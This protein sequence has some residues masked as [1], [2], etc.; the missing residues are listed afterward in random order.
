MLSPIE[1]HGPESI[2]LAGRRGFRYWV[3]NPY[4]LLHQADVDKALSSFPLVVFLPN[5]DPAHTPVLIGLQGM[6]APMHWN[7]FLVPHLV[8]RGIACVL[9]ETPLAGERSLILDG[10]DDILRKMTPLVERGIPLTIQL[11]RGMFEAVA[12]DFA[13]V[14]NLLRERHGLTDERV[15]LLGVSLGCLLSAFAFL[16]DGIGQRL[17]GIIGHADLQAF[18]QSYSPYLTPLLSSSPA[19]LVARA[20]A[21]FIGSYPQAAVEFMAI[22]S[23]LSAG[24]AT[25]LL[26]NPMSYADR[27]G[28]DRR[29]RFLVGRNDNILRP[30]DAVRCAEAFPGGEC[31]V[32]PGLGHGVSVS[33]PSFEQHVRYYVA[34]QLGDWESV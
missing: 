23:E 5:R 28:P 3:H 24:S 21:M 17:L 12:Q 7:A 25:S 20:L 19:W 26:I 11:V 4:D 2:E 6:A 9:F 18:A 33:G 32:V 13:L 34:T 10:S 16:R 22:L 30:S 29:I 15:A 8:D 1:I 27:L 31:Y 14:R